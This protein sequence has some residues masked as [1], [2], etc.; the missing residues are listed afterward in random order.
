MV[1]GVAL[2]AYPFVSDWF[3]RIERDNVQQGYDDTVSE[4]PKEDL[5]SEMEAAQKYNSDLLRGNNIAADPFDPNKLTDYSDKRYWQILNLNDDG[6]MGTITIPKLDV[7]VPIYH[8]TGDDVLQKG[9]GHMA[10][11]SLPVGGDSTHAVLAGHTGLPNMVVFDRLDTLEVGDYFVIHVLDQDLAYR[12]YEKETVLPDQTESLAV[13]QGRDLVTLVTCT[14][15]G[16]NTHRLLVHAERCDVPAEYYEDNHGVGPAEQATNVIADPVS[17]FSLVGG[18]V[19][20]AGS[21]F[22][23]V[24]LRRQGR[25]EAPARRRK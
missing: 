19:A 1:A 24:Q 21:I 18:A 10:T 14:P 22:L 9:V 11:S 25:D 17:L 12:V 4:T 2:I 7:S 3:S 15:Y 5:S 13:Q 23:L 16:V 8:G 20:L 6:V